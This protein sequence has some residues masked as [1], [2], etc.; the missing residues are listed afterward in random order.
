MTKELIGQQ[1]KKKLNAVGR[2][3]SIFTQGSYKKLLSKTELRESLGLL[4]KRT[5]VQEKVDPV[6]LKAMFSIMNNNSTDSSPGSVEERSPVG[7]R[8]HLSG[9]NIKIKPAHQRFASTI[10]VQGAGDSEDHR[11]PPKMEDSFS[12]KLNTISK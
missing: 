3:R 9:L 5:S 1:L 12:L 10:N 6:D 7:G 2:N 4:N 8:P 11:S